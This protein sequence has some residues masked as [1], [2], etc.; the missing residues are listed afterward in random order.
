MQL[1]MIGTFD[2]R[3]WRPLGQ[4]LGTVGSVEALCVADTTG[5]ASPAP[6]LYAAGLFSDFSGGPQT[7]LERWDGSQ[8]HDITG[9]RGPLMSL[10]LFDED[11]PGPQ[12]PSLF[13]GG[14]ILEWPGGINASLL[15]WD[16]QA[17][18]LPGTGLGPRNARSYVMSMTIF[19]DDGPG[20]RTP[21]LYVA[22]TFETAGG[23]VVNNIARWD[24]NNWEA[25]GLGLLGGVD[26]LA[27]FD[28]D[29]PGPEPPMLYAAGWYRTPGGHSNALLSRWDG[30]QWS[31]VP[32]YDGGGVYALHVFDDD[33]DGP[34]KPSLFVSGLFHRVN[35]V[36]SPGLIK[37]DGSQWLAVGGGLGGVTGAHADAMGIFDEDGDP[38]TPPGLYMGGSF[39]SAGGLWAPGLARWGCAYTACYADCEAS[40][41]LGTLDIFDYLCFQ[42]RFVTTDPYA[43]DCDTSTGNGVC[44]LLDF[45]CFQRAFLSGCP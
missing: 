24:G 42:H 7:N 5:V 39:L 28:A 6:G 30:T 27:V 8:W 41:G 37:W 20:P 13:V 18:S 35:G 1:N 16:G 22:G 19:D 11:G 9:L 23:I 31:E 25:L 2:G 33:G 4:G 12:E 21:A 40:T 10:H 38:A 14:G 17:F 15:R 43:C 26:A 34:N 32:G 29:G 44:D 45:L 36:L 3:V